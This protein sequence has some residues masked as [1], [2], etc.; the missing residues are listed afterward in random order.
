M[1]FLKSYLVIALSMLTILSCQ[2]EYSLE[3]A[4]GIATGSLKSDT[5]GDCF[6]SSVNGIFK[7]DSTLGAGNSIDVQLNLTTGGA[8]TLLSDTVNGYYFKGSGSAAAG[9]QTVRLRGFGKPLAAGANEFRI[10]FGAS[11]CFIN[12]MVLTSSATVAQF[13]LAGGPGVCTAA[14]ATGT[15][16]KDVPLNSSNT[17]TVNVNVTALGAYTLG[18]VAA[19]GMFFTSTGTFTTLGAQNVTLNGGGTPT[20]AGATSVAVGGASTSCV[21]GIVVAPA[22][23]TSAVYTLGGAPGN[24]TGI[25]LAGTYQAGL[26]TGAANT[27]L[28]DVQVTTPGSYTI[29]TAPVNG[30]TFSGSGNFVNTNPQTVTLTATGTPAAAGSFE[31]TPIGIASACKFSVVFTAAA[32]PAVFT[33]QGA[34]GACTGAT[35]AGTFTAGTALTAANTVTVNANVSTIGSY[36]LTANTV[37]GMTFTATGVFTGT[38]NQPIVLRATGNTPVAA[39]SNSFTIGVTGC[40]FSVTVVAAGSS[41]IFQCKIDGV[42]NT[43]LDFAEGSYFVPGDLLISGDNQ[44]LGT[45]FLLS[46]NKSSSGGTVTAGTYLNTLAASLAGGYLINGNFGDAANVVWAPKGFLFGTPDPFT[47]IVTSITATRVIGTFSGTIRDN[48]GSGTNTK[49]VTEGVFNLPIN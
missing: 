35:V 48:F 10:A 34:P 39:G 21:F 11:E 49:T 46:I 45:D 25:V 23:S 36:S 43:F 7:I 12:V 30:V 27:A 24:C 40:T 42:L 38:G 32:A 15:Y 5:F 22:A 20:I 18:A 31:Y 41:N 37:N 28:F 19:N 17:L 9:L 6:P 44:V 16:V 3:D 8:Y 29:T 33:L 4:G 14:S 1:K 2:K 26:A 13:T 47:I